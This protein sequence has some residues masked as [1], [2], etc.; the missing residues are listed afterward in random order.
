M[1]YQS[2]RFIPSK[3]T[4]VTDLQQ[5]DG[6]LDFHQIPRQEGAIFGCETFNSC[7]QSEESSDTEEHMNQFEPAFVEEKNVFSSNPKSSSSSI[8]LIDDEE[9]KSP[10]QEQHRKV[11]HCQNYFRVVDFSVI[12]MQPL[13]PIKEEDEQEKCMEYSERPQIYNNDI[14]AREF[15]FQF[16]SDPNNN[17]NMDFREDLKIVKQ[18]EIS[19]EGQQIVQGL[20]P[21]QSEGNSWMN[22]AR[23]GLCS[24]S[25]LSPSVNNNAPLPPSQSKVDHGSQQNLNSS[26]LEGSRFL[27]CQ[28]SNRARELP[29][30]RQKR[31]PQ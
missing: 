14:Y 24:N 9:E 28:K 29:T 30:K 3:F 25:I 19:I 16:E 27:L 23:M 31:Y 26:K 1:P 5:N 11:D 6:L 10:L 7:P 21:D 12:G 18:N 4:R 13:A 8:S 22:F 20:T 2:G 15:Q 17:Q